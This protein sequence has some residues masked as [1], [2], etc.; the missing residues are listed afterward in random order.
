MRLPLR[1]PSAELIIHAAANK[2]INQID[3]ALPYDH[4]P[5]WLA[6]Q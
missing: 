1:S 5:T 3:G 2:D 4:I 6:W